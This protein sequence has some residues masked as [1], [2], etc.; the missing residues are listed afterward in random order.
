MWEPPGEDEYWVFPDI[1][2]LITSSNLR[3]TLQDLEGVIINCHTDVANVKEAKRE[4]LDRIWENVYE[5]DKLHTFKF[6][7]LSGVIEGISET[8]QYFADALDPQHHHGEGTSLLLQYPGPFKNILK[9]APK[10]E[11]FYDLQMQMQIAA[12]LKEARFSEEE[13]KDASEKER[14][15]ILQE[16]YEE[17]RLIMGISSNKD[18]VFTSIP[19]PAEGFDLL[20]TYSHSE[21]LL[22]LNS[23]MLNDPDSFDF[24]ITVI[25][26]ARHAYQREAVDDPGCHVVSEETRGVWE[27]N[28]DNY[29]K[30]KTISM[31]I[32]GSLL[33][34]TQV[35]LLD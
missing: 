26:E 24:F 19:Q 28:F 8:I 2:N 12:L 16:F 29:M 5:A 27:E 21:T 18:I 23:D 13:W 32:A 34:W 31:N 33:N 30:E 9:S 4:E 6:S 17:V 35:I 7:R 25:H 20:G 11:Y 1:S 10:L 22:R 14:M 3:G 15:K